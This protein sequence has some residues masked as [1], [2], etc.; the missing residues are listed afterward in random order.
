MAGARGGSFKE[1]ISP[2]LKAKIAEAERRFGINSREYRALTSQYFASPEENRI[3]PWERRRHYEAEVQL[4]FEGKPLIGIE[5]LYRRTIL[6]EPSTVCAAHC[7][8]CL[9]G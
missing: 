2:F 9:R 4:A 1:L 8:W 3:L 6:I 5:R 7:R